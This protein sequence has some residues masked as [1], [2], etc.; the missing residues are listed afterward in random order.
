[1]SPSMNHPSTAPSQIHVADLS[2]AFRDVPVATD[3]P[4]GT[5]LAAA[6]GFRP[7]QQATVLEILQNGELEDVRPDEV[8]GLQ[9]STRKFIIVASDRSYK[10]AINDRPIV[11]PARM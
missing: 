3:A 10:L 7:E 11:W 6:A 2:L 9:D 1:M 8:V 5:Q 4:T